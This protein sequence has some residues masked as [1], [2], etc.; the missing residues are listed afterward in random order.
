MSED[1]HHTTSSYQNNDADAGTPLRPIAKKGGPP[2][3]LLG[4]IF[5]KLFSV[6]LRL[7]LG[8]DRL[9]QLRQLRFC[10]DQ[11][12]LGIQMGPRHHDSFVHSS[13]VNWTD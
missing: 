5:T 6:F 11:S 2:P 9:R 8:C 12:E 3:T 10:D 4:K 1:P 13:S 7:P